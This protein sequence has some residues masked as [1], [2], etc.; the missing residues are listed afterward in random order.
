[1][2]VPGTVIQERKDWRWP[3][4]FLRAAHVFLPDDLTQTRQDRL[5]GFLNELGAKDARD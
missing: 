5:D 1:M 2:T 4:L 3:R